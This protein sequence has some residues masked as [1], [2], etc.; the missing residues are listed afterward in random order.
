MNIA[1]SVSNA[2][3]KMNKEKWQKKGVACARS[4]VGSPAHSLPAGSLPSTSQPEAKSR[5]ARS[6]E[7]GS[8]NLLSALEGLRGNGD[9]G[10]NMDLS[11]T[12]NSTCQ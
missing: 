8:Y 9:T 6:R 12:P 11:P 3:P 2:W 10:A 7:V 5:M 1:T 4:E